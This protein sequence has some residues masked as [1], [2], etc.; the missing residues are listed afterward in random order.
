MN[1]LLKVYGAKSNQKKKM[2]NFQS[3]ALGQRKGQKYYS[4]F[5]IYQFFLYGSRPQTKM[6]LY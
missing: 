4:V 1:A 2:D 3:L 5:P 6:A